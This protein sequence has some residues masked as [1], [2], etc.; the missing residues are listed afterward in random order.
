MVAK[1][2]TRNSVTAVAVVRV[3]VPDRFRPAHV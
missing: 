2:R 1:P 3:R